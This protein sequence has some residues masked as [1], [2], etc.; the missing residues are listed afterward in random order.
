L[1]LRTGRHNS[2]PGLAIG[3]VGIDSLT[4]AAGD[5]GPPLLS[6]GIDIVVIAVGVR[7]RRGAVV[8]DGRRPAGRSRGAAGWAGGL[9]APG[10]RGCAPPTVS[11]SALLAGGA[12]LPTFL[13]CHREEAEQAQGG[14]RGAIEGA[15]PEAANNVRRR[16]SCADAAWATDNATAGDARGLVSYGIQPGPTLRQGAVADLTLIASLSL[17]PRCQPSLRPVAKLL[18]TP[19]L[20]ARGSHL[21]SWRSQNLQPLDLA[22]L[23]VFG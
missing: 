12:E 9:A 8:G 23:L 3:L 11:R 4:A 21:R 2:L 10:N 14:V 15:G 7:A 20:F 13:S 5:F 22:L 18:R 16:R 19:R 1:L 6:D 17:E